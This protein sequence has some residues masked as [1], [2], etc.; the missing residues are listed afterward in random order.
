MR[1]RSKGQPWQA[2]VIQTRPIAHAHSLQRTGNAS[3]SNSNTHTCACARASSPWSTK[4]PNAS[5]HSGGHTGGSNT[6]T[7]A[8]ARP[9]SQTGKKV[10]HANAHRHRVLAAAQPNP[11]ASQ[12]PP[13]RLPTGSQQPP[14]QVGQKMLE[15]NAHCNSRFRV[16][17]DFGGQFCAIEA[18][19]S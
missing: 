17:I 2:K 14:R 13:A 16:A 8:C 3:K 1:A 7:C 11:T 5:A 15:A 6:H 19:A 12:Q 10:P 9:S 18:N 4:A